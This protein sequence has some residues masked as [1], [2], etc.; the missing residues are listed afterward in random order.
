MWI[1]REK[2]AGCAVLHGHFDEKY[3]FRCGVARWLRRCSKNKNKC[4]NSSYVLF[5]MPPYYTILVHFIHI[6]AYLK[7]VYEEIYTLHHVF[8]I[9]LC[10][11]PTVLLLPFFPFWLYS[12]I[13]FHRCF[14]RM[15]RLNIENEIER[16]LYRIYLFCCEILCGVEIE[17]QHS[18]TNANRMW[19]WQHSGIFCLWTNYL[20]FERCAPMLHRL[21]AIFG[22]D[23]NIFKRIF[24]FQFVKMNQLTGEG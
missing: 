4:R 8:Y 3:L 23:R 5:L 1:I 15:P 22:T 6:I 16:K 18:N 21:D 7:A 13:F 19:K 12:H 2:S 9:S 11:P 17:R 14:V 24:E 10:R 20:A